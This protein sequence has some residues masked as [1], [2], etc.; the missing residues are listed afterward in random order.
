MLIKDLK[1]I[2]LMVVTDRQ[3]NANGTYSDIYSLK[4]SYNVKIQE[5]N[6]EISAE[7][8]GAD[9]IKML[10][11]GSPLKDLEKFLLTK[12]QNKEDNISKY[13]IILD[14]TDYRIKAVKM[15]GIDIERY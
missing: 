14:N 6:D 7:A 15:S 13:K 2:D 9:I 8:Y 12:V 1:K 3:K 5:L 10:K 11:I 4:K